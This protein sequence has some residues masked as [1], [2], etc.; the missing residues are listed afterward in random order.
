MFVSEFQL[1][2]SVVRER[3]LAA[4][5]EVSRRSEH[6]RCCGDGLVV[7]SIVEAV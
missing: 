3:S 5:G 7:L 2:V 1:F 4:M 6:P